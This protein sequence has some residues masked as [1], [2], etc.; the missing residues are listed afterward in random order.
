MLSVILASCH[1]H[2][3]SEELETL[4]AQTKLENQNKALVKAYIE[5]WNKQREAFGV[6]G[7][8]RMVFGHPGNCRAPFS[9]TKTSR[10]K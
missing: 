10:M 8:S 6:Q 9:R 5:T 7:S 3:E 2:H 4:K 1:D